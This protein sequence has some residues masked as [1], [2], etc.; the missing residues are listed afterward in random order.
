MNKKKH[1]NFIDIILIVLILAVAAVAYLISHR[2]G[3]DVQ[4]LIPCTY[5]IEVSELNEDMASCVKVGDALVDNVRHYAIG[6][7]TKVEVVPYTVSVPDET[8]GVIRAVEVPGKINLLLTV[9]VQTV[10][11]ESSIYTE[12][13]YLIRIGTEVS[14]AGGSM[15]CVGRIID[16]ER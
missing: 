5:T 3:G 6:T 13:G 12:S 4:T 16:I 15:Y 1:P 7:V 8:A 10:Q 2:G 9:E 11:N 14:C